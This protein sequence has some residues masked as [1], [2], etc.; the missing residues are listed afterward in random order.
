MDDEFVLTSDRL[1]VGDEIARGSNGAVC[2]AKLDEMAVC[3]KV[4]RGA[5][6]LA[7][8]FP[9]AFRGSSRTRRRWSCARRRHSVLALRCVL[10]FFG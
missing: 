4:C 1:E 2:K 5:A 9:W 3:A 8:P 7:G 10:Y 6:L